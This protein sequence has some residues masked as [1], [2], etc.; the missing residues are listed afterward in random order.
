MSPL[1]SHLPSPISHSLLP[2]K[3]KRSVQP[4]N[5]LNYPGAKSGSDVKHPTALPR[6]K[7]SAPPPHNH[8]HKASRS[9]RTRFHSRYARRHCPESHAYSTCTILNDTQSP[10][11]FSVKILKRSRAGS[12]NLHLSKDSATGHT[13]FRRAPALLHILRIPSSYQALNLGA[14]VAVA[15]ARHTTSTHYIIEA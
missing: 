4:R 3:I 9:P 11:R 14:T 5:R 10:V 1:H 2:S 6:E 13:P 7:S 12:T 8:R 15:V